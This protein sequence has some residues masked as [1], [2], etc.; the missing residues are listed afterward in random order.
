MSNLSDIGFPARTGKEFGQLIELAITRG[1]RLPCEKG[2]YLKYSDPS[3][4]ELYCQVNKKN[5]V[6]GM[7]PHYKGKSKFPVALTSKVER[8]ESALDGSFH[9]WAA[10]TDPDNPESGAY[11]FVMDLPDFYTLSPIVFPHHTHLQLAAF[12]QQDF[13]LYGSEQEYLDSRKEGVKF[14]TRS[15]IPTGLFSNNQED[16]GPSSPEAY[17]MINGI[18]KEWEKKTNGITGQPFYWI[19]IETLGGDL[20]VLADPVL[21]KQDPV[22]GGVL[23]GQ[24]WLSARVF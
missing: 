21:V 20:D 5:E 7:N 11:P 2:A 1:E 18:I 19:F 10:P 12:A 3:G 6:L 16:E 8:S 13:Q 17:G 22:N 14:S 9:G 23:T 15:F 24:F 4:A